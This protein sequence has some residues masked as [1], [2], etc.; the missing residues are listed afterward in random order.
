V[1]IPVVTDLSSWSSHSLDLSAV[2]HE[3]PTPPP[4]IRG[5]GIAESPAAQPEID[6]ANQLHSQVHDISSCPAVSADTE[7]QYSLKSRGRDYALITVKSH[8]L[9]AHDPPLLYFGEV[10]KGFVVLSLNDLGEVRSIDVV[11]RMLHSDP[12]RPSFETKCVLLPQQLDDSHRI[13]GGRCCWPFAITPTTPSVLSSDSSSTTGSSLGQR[14]L[15]SYGAVADPTLQ[16]VVTIHRR[17]PLTQ[18]V[19][20]K[21]KIC[22]V[23]SPDP[24]VRSSPSPISVDV[25]YGSPA[26][27]SWPEQIFPLVTARG[28]IFRQDHVEVECSLVTPSSYPIG[29]TIPLHLILTSKSREALALF[30][31]PHV[32]DVRL[33][34]VLVFGKQALS[35]QPLTLKNRGSYHRMDLAAK[36]QWEPEGHAEELPSSDGH[37][38][39]LA[40]QAERKASARSAR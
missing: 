38:A 30:G 29:D 20:I 16:L 7:H 31:M 1:H 25:P 14:S 2:L 13:S 27:S 26:G 18:N 40:H 22:Y 32:V 8:A 34:K 36:A 28:V 23:P 11:L 3:F 35:I 17:G 37:S 33:Q 19:G 9:N 12:I 5:D 24:S 21:Q 6:L 39:S 15:R 4:Y 10:L